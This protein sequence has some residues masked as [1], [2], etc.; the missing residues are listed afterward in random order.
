V[1]DPLA[2]GVDL[3]LHVECGARRD[4]DGVLDRV[5]VRLVAVSVQKLGKLALP[6]LK[7]LGEIPE[8]VNFAV[9]NLTVKSALK[10]NQIYF[11]TGEISDLDRAVNS[12]VHITCW[13]KK[14]VENIP[15]L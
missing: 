3:G 6:F 12:T 9:K 1:H 11:S 2:G 8:N 14:K 5:C 10:A 15:D 4:A 7:G 13:G